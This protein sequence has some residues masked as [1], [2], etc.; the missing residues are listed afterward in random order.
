MAKFTPPKP[1]FQAPRATKGGSGM[2]PP[3]P[4]TTTAPR[5]SS[6]GSGMSPP[7]AVASV[8][9]TTGGKDM[10]PPAVDST[11]SQFVDPIPTRKT[12]KFTPKKAG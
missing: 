8:R 2:N 9:S 5:S 10:T 12:G 11:S 4:H 1:D 7:A 6:G 3:A